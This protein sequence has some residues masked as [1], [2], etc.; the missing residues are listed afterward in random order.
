VIGLPWQVSTQHGLDEFAWV[1]AGF[2]ANECTILLSMMRHRICQLTDDANSAAGK[3][4]RDSCL[5]MHLGSTGCVQIPIVDVELRPTQAQ[6]SDVT[7]FPAVA[8]RPVQT[9]WC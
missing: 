6:G 7:Q 9:S 3:L 8:A 1:G 4:A 2:M 5:H